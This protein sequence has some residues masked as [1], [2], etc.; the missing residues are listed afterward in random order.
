MSSFALVPADAVEPARLHAAF[1]QAFADYLIGPFEL[2]L[3]QWPQFLARQGVNLA[4]SRV[5]MNGNEPL[6]FCLAAPRPEVR[7]WRLGTMGAVPAARGSGAAPVLL[8]DFT[9]RA[10]AA[11]MACVELECFAQNTRAVRLYEGRGFATVDTL[12]GYERAASPVA[13]AAPSAP[14]AIALEDAFDWLDECL[15]SG[16]ELPLQ[17]TARALRTS[18]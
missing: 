17:V 9:V 14:T 5:A 12:H 2:A 10:K 4:L 13:Q 16:C 15:Q 3:A 11:G 8:G 1:T 6:A 7:S 18:L